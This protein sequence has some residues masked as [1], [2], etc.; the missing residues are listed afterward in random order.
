MWITNTHPPIGDGMLAVPSTSKIGFECDP[1][2]QESLRLLDFTS[3]E[4]HGLPTKLYF[5]E[6][7]GAFANAQG[8]FMEYASVFEEVDLRPPGK[9]KNVTSPRAEDRNISAKSGGLA[10]QQELVDYWALFFPGA[11]IWNSEIAPILPWY[12]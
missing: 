12:S 4:N 1:F 7:L 8:W 9:N 6:R 10:A 11:P 5:I 3:G 2:G